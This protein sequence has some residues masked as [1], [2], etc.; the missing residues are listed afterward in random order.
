MSVF[1]KAIIEDGYPKTLSERT[2]KDLFDQRVRV[3][4]ARTG[5][6][7]GRNEFSQQLWCC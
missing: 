3:R 6:F 7:G 5:A 4:E 1:F 2:R